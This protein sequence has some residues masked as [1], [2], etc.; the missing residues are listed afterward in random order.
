MRDKRYYEFRDRVFT[1]IARMKQKDVSDAIMA[2]E[3]VSQYKLINTLY[4]RGVSFSEVVC[5]LIDKQE[6]KGRKLFGIL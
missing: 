6:V 2:S 1:A 5:T 3:A 4:D